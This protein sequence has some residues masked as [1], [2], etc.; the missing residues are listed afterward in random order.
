M[1]A[2]EQTRVILDIDLWSEPMEGSLSCEQD[3]DAHFIGWIQLTQALNR[4]LR[5]QRERKAQGHRAEV[6]RDDPPT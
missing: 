5:N 3:P 2:R 1:K 4:A 6:A